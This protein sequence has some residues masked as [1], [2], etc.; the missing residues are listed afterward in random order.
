MKII[1]TLLTTALLIVPISGCAIDVA[2]LA[3][4]FTRPTVVLEDPTLWTC[5]LEAVKLQTKQG[6]DDCQKCH[7]RQ[8]SAATGDRQ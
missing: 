6:M 5:P 7:E 1:P 3:Q 4:Q 8:P 2:K